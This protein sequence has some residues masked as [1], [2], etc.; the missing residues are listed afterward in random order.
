MPRDGLIVLG[1]MVA[2]VAG[3][4]AFPVVA[5]ESDTDVGVE[6]VNIFA[7]NAAWSNL[8]HRDESA[9]RF[10][11][12]F[13]NK[14]WTG[15][16]CYGN[17]DAWERDFKEE[18][19]GGN[20][21]SYIDRCDIAM[22]CT[23]GDSTGFHFNSTRD[24]QVLRIAEAE[25]GDDKDLEWIIL[26]CCL[27]MDVNRHLDWEAVFH[28][29]HIIS[30]FSTSAHDKP[31][32]GYY[33]AGKLFKS[34]TVEQAW[35]YACDMTEGNDIECASKGVLNPEN[36]FDDCIHGEGSVAKDSDDATGFWYV[37]YNCG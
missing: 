21:D 8:S 35:K 4:L 30:G 31:W 34:W 19:Q 1:V 25:W 27:C 37:K 7:S 6:W 2:V 23:H 9:S 22:V 28:E 13:T 3:L 18:S 24:D 33:M 12:R 36:T 5:S 14:G 32:R 10:Y 16:F 26:D 29:L 11:N 20:D 17:N 15:R